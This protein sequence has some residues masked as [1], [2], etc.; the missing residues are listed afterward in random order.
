MGLAEYIDLLTA[1]HELMQ[2]T[3]GKAPYK[4]QLDWLNQIRPYALVKHGEQNQQRSSVTPSASS[5]AK[6]D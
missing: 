3:S 4:S 5:Q 6:A 2:T 1:L